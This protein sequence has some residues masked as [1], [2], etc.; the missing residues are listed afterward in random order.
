MLKVI[1]SIVV[2]SMLVLL[3]IIIL[4]M[5]YTHHGFSSGSWFNKNGDALIIRNKGVLGDSEMIIAEQNGEKYNILKYKCKMIVNPLSLPHKFTMY[6]LDDT[7]LK[8]KIN[9]FTG[10][11]KLYN[12]DIYYGVFSKSNVN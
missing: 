4:T 10:K 1:F 9:M 5:Y 7:K 8:A 6:M 12:G 11:L 3:V 2:L